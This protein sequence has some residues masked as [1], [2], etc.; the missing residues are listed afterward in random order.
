VFNAIQIEKSLKVTIVW[1]SN[2]TWERRPAAALTGTIIMMPSFQ[3]T[4]T[5]FRNGPNL[6]P[7]EPIVFGRTER[8][9]ALRSRF[10]KVAALKMPVLVEGESGTGKDIIARMLHQR[11]PWM[12]GVFVKVRCSC[13]PDSFD[14]LL[15]SSAGVV[16]CGPQAAPDPVQLACHGTL[17]LDEISETNAALQTKLLRLLQEGQLC[18][19]NLKRCKVNLRVICATNC[20]L[21]DAAERGSFRRDLLYRINVLT[22]RVPPLR[23]RMIDIPDFVNYFLHLFSNTYNCQA[24]RLSRSMLE[25]LLGH[26]WPGNIRELENLMKRYV[27]F[28]CEEAFCNALVGH[29]HK[30]IAPE[31]SAPGAV[32]LKELTKNAVRELEREA[33]LRVLQENH[34]NRKRA[35]CALNISYRALLYKLKDAQIASRPSPSGQLAL[36]LAANKAVV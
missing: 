30:Q 31:L 25:S 5:E 33:I 3:T 15:E 6:L 27:L 13:I 18:S 7:P 23:E 16:A 21:E 19:I 17:F 24:K 22:L 1:N 26:S 10:E 9:Q 28:G 34:W 35:A 12:S 14:D 8:M 20:G 4:A 11:S 32:P 29:A 36:G 2:C